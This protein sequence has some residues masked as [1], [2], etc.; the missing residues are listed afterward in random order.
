MRSH[1]L[2]NIALPV[3]LDAGPG[4]D[5]FVFRSNLGSNTIN[6]FAAGT[7]SMFDHVVFADYGAVQSHMQQVGSTS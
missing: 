3:R 1:Y 7:D 4:A 6:G 2:I 5:T